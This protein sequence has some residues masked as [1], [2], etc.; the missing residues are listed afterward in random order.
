MTSRR[1]RADQVW[2]HGTKWLCP[3]L[4]CQPSCSHGATAADHSTADRSLSWWCV[5]ND[6]L[7]IR[8]KFWLV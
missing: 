8:L 1:N 4:T 7:N 3:W 6:W 2:D 5:S